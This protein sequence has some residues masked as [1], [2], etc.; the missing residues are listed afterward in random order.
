MR[1]WLYSKLQ[2]A[3]APPLRTHRTSSAHDEERCQWPSFSQVSDPVTTPR[4]GDSVA[5]LSAGLFSLSFATALFTLSIFKLLSFFIMPSLFFDLLF[6]GFPVGAFLAARWLPLG[7]GSL[8]QSLWGLQATMATS[9]GCC[10]LAKPF[11]YL[12]AHLF[13]IELSGLIGQIAVFAGLF[14]PFFAAYGMC[15]YLGY[16]YGRS[17]LGGRMRLVVCPRAVRGGRSLPF[18]QGGPADPGH[19]GFQLLA[20]L[21][22]AGSIAA[23]GTGTHA[24]AVA[25]LEALV[26]EWPC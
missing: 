21:G 5:A 22:V 20:F 17:R 19:G 23:L 3:P 16:Q 1:L 7:R 12:R 4:R 2:I 6:I 18:P 10:L 24:R 25:G 13:D 8:L 9:V 26:L 14:L 15:E 11:D